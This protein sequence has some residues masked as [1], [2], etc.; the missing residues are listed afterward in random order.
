M[1]D[2]TEQLVKA[3]Q[4]RQPSPALRRRIFAA[5]PAELSRAPVNGAGFTRWLV[6]ALGCFVVFTGIA[7]DPSMQ[8]P[9][10]F[11]PPAGQQVAYSVEAVHKD[12]CGAKNTVPANNFEWTV[13]QPSVSSSDSFAGSVTNSLHQSAS[14]I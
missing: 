14:R 12:W 10:S 5:E 13:S 8:V 4:P 1:N 9:G 7:L 3:W 6:P 11:A 2:S